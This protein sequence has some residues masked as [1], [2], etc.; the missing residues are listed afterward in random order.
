MKLEADFDISGK[1]QARDH[2]IGRGRVSFWMLNYLSWLIEPLQQE[3]TFKYLCFI[4]D[5]GHW[6][7]SVAQHLFKILANWPLEIDDSIENMEPIQ[8]IIDWFFLWSC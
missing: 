5:V 6:N 4:V 8:L 7:Q 2:L 1:N 3:P